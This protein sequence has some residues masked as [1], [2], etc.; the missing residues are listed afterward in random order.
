MICCRQFLKEVLVVFHPETWGTLIQFDEHIF[1]QMGGT[2][3]LEASQIISIVSN[4]YLQTISAIWKGS[5]N[6]ILRGLRGLTNH[7]Y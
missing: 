1:F 6:P 3:Y 4:P 7:R 2:N 5:H